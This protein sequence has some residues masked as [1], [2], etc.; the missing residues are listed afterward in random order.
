MLDKREHYCVCSF[1]KQFFVIGGVNTNSFMKYDLNTE[2]W[3]NKANT[4]EIRYGSACTVFEGKIV[5]FGGY[6]IYGDLKGVRSVESY[7]HHE[8]KW[9]FLP[10]MIYASYFHEVFSMGN[11]MLVIGGSGFEAF[12]SF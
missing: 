5:V 9:T 8:N 4:S 11:K 7:D 2:R 1:L 3:T 10:E 12:D 6:D